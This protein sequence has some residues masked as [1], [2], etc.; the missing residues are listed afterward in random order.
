MSPQVSHFVIFP[1]PR[2]QCGHGLLRLKFG[3]LRKS[4]GIG[5]GMFAYG[6]FSHNSL[7]NP[8]NGE[9]NTCHPPLLVEPIIVLEMVGA[10]FRRF[11]VVSPPG[12]VPCP[13]RSRPA[14]FQPGGSLS[15]L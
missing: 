10:P 14:N 15:V 7:L 8:E 6:H 5:R 2:V 3:I 11:A 1:P 9:A 13:E 4:H 12:S